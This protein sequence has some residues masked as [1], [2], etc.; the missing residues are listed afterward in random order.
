[1]GVAK[2]EFEKSDE[3][4]DQLTDVFTILTEDNQAPLLDRS[5]PFMEEIVATKEGVTKNL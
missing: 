5:A 2:S 4:N 3:Y 1:M